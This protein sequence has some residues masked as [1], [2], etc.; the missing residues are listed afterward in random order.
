MSGDRRKDKRTLAAHARGPNDGTKTPAL[1]FRAVSEPAGAEEAAGEGP[2][3]R[4]ADAGARAGAARPGPG[5]DGRAGRPLP[6]AVVV[7]GEGREVE[8]PAV[9]V[10][11][12]PAPLPPR[13]LSKLVEVEFAEDVAAA[14]GAFLFRPPAFCPPLAPFLPFTAEAADVS[15]PA[16]RVAVDDAPVLVVAVAF[17]SLASRFS[18]WAHQRMNA[19][20]SSA[21]S[22]SASSARSS[23]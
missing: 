8:A 10:E 1:T 20:S 4:M 5:R 23:A 11:P 19:T 12:L 9:V 22:F 13:G 17:A 15:R 14:E 18:S 16:P 7:A 2:G 21:R 6:P 3:G